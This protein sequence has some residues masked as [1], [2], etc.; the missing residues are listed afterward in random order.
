MYLIGID[1][2]GTHTDAALL[3][4]SS[5]VALAK[6]PTDHGDLFA[7][8][9]KAL[10]EIWHFYPGDGP[11]RLQLSTTLSTNAIV[12]GKGAPTQVVAV[13]GPGVNLASLDLPFTVHEL[14]GYIDHRGREAYPLDPRSSRA[15]GAFWA[16]EKGR[17][18]RL[19]GSFPSATPPT[20]SRSA[21][22]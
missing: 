6:V 3:R 9:R 20:N 14:S 12:E 8:T 7:S 11:C 5:V 17:R 16:G 1:V 18:W 21:L 22:S 4:D 10:E 19:W 13:P 2:G 15:S